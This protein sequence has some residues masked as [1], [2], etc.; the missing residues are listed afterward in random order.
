[1]DGRKHMLGNGS[2]LLS[3]Y[4]IMEKDTVRMGEEGTPYSRR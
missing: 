3:L 4:L 2:Q 1:M